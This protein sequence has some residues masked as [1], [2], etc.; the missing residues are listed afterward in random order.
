[1]S[2]FW[3]L[4]GP[5]QTLILAAQQERLPQVIYWGPPLPTSDDCAALAAAHT[6]DVTGGM[7]D[8]N[9]ELSIC[10][11]S[12]QSFP[13][14]PGLMCRDAQ[15]RVLRPKFRFVKDLAKEHSLCLTYTDKDL[16][17]TYEAHFELTAS[18]NMLT[19]WSRLEATRPLMLHWLA[20][21]VFPA[22]QLSDSMMSFSGRWIGEFQTHSIPWRPGIHKR[23]SRTG[24]QRA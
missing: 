16:G 7:L 15:G 21:P 1:M 17:L 24:P 2:Q 8:A 18:S 9:P 19:C 12:S 4:D 20:A 11:E 14:Q 5:L 22:P 6:M 10:P 3:R 23:E 13:G